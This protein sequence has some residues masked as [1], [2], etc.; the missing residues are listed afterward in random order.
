MKLFLINK[1]KKPSLVAIK[2]NTNNGGKLTV[3]ESINA[4]FEKIQAHSRNAVFKQH[5]KK[6]T[7]YNSVML[8]DRGNTFRL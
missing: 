2:K 7:L 6:K 4:R 8:K 5:F 3:S 1:Q